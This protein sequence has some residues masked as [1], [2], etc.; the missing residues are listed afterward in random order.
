MFRELNWFS[1]IIL[2][3]AGLSAV[4]GYII[5]NRRKKIQCG[6]VERG[7]RRR[8]QLLE[9]VVQDLEFETEESKMKAQIDKLV[10]ERPEAVAQ[11]LRT[12]LNG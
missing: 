11:L 10:D 8:R 3:L 1:L 6:R 9:H 12:W 7:Y 5:Y 2:A 4:A